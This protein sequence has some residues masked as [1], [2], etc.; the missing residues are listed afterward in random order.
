MRRS[1]E[2]RPPWLCHPLTAPGGLPGHHPGGQRGHLPTSRQV[3]Q[4]GLGPG[5]AGR[6]QP[7]CSWRLPLALLS[8]R[9][10]RVGSILRGAST[11]ASD[12][13]HV[14]PHMNGLLPEY[15]PPLKCQPLGD[16]DCVLFILVSPA[17]HRAGILG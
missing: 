6:A 4:L 2:D 9:W 15:C 3:E 13:Q 12:T 1:R 7:P 17:P 16:R 5:A 14:S 10:V 8:A 11:C